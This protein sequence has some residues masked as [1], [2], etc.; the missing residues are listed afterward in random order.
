MIEFNH[1]AHNN[2]KLSFDNESITPCSERP[3]NGENSSEGWSAPPNHDNLVNM[4]SAAAHP[5]PTD[6]EN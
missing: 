3:G 2:L 4:V 1:Q 6:T 5:P